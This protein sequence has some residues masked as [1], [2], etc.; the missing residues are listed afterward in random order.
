M[1][2]MQLDAAIPGFGQPRGDL[3]QLGGR[4]PL[5]SGAQTPSP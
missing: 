1:V 4:G 5:G 2:R 3:G